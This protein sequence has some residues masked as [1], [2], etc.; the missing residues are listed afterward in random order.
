MDGYSIRVLLDRPAGSDV[1]APVPEELASRLLRAAGT[2]VT[3]VDIDDLGPEVT[4]ARIELGT[5]AGT[6][7]V[8]GRLADGLALAAAA[9]APVRVA[10]PVMDRLAVP[11]HGDDLL[12]PF[13][14][15]APAATYA[16]P[17]P[18][19]RNL[20]FTEGLDGWQLHGSFLRDASG[21]HWQDYACAAERG[22]A[23]LRSA[24]PQP[25]GCAHLGQE[26][27][28]D[29]YRGRSVVFRA[30]LRAE[31]VTGLARLYLRVQTRPIHEHH[32]AAVTGRRD[33]TGHKVSAPVPEG[34]VFVE[35]GV[36]FDGPGR[37]ELRKA[38]LTR[39]L[40]IPV[41]CP[42]LSGSRLVW[43]ATQPVRLRSGLR[44]A[45]CLA[46]VT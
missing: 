29:D 33:W 46:S 30:E 41:P 35:F 10:D 2:T 31:D 26:I 6:R 45:A 1:M 7:E 11:V 21:S 9:G 20:A 43:L 13:L 27:R 19:P 5:P 39:R 44:R 15:R 8:M 18:R 14:E 42:S 23:I 40:R 4:A 16:M 24:V 28:A 3:A 34:A 38:R 22:S 36:L 32:A 37:I 12:G 17:R 25:Y